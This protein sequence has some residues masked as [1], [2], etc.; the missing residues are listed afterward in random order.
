MGDE[1]GSK[2]NREN[3]KNWWNILF[4]KNFIFFTKGSLRQSQLTSFSLRKTF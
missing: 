3:L 1:L 2:N 4:I